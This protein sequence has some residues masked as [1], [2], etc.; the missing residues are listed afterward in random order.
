[1]AAGSRPGHPEAR[2]RPKSQ[3]RGGPGPHAKPDGQILVFWI[4]ALE[5]LARLLC[6]VR[7][8]KSAQS[9]QINGFTRRNYHR[10]MVLLLPTTAIALSM[11]DPAGYVE[12]A[13]YLP[14]NHSSMLKT[15][16]CM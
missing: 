15:F 14:A 2:G 9:F 8:H 16:N 7:E 6:P 10:K 4:I 5:Q 11:A 12:H 13:D 3:E 1:M